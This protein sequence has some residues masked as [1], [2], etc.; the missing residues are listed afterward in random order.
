[1]NPQLLNVA[2]AAFGG[3]GVV[4][5]KKIYETAR[6]RLSGRDTLVKYSTFIRRHASNRRELEDLVSDKHGP[7]SIIMQGVDA[8]YIAIGGKDPSVVVLYLRNPEDAALF[9][10][11]LDHLDDPETVYAIASRQKPAQSADPDCGECMEFAREAK[12]STENTWLRFSNGKDITDEKVDDA[13]LTQVISLARSRDKTLSQSGACHISVKRLCPQ[14]KHCSVIV[15]PT[16]SSFRK[17]FRKEY[18]TDDLTRFA[19]ADLYDKIINVRR[20]MA[21]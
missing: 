3:I 4:L 20:K 13:M 7:G 12:G 8:A 15:I 18:G 6:N 10:A 19:A 9:R 14:T 2:C 1:M 17:S 16:S 11:C 5:V 21:A